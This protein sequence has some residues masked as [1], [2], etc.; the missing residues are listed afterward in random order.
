M[1]SFTG[2]IKVSTQVLLHV[3][4][5]LFLHTNFLVAF[6]DLTAGVCEN[7]DLD[8]KE[9][10]WPI[11]QKALSECSLDFLHILISKLGYWVAPVLPL[12]PKQR[13]I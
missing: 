4:D 8:S 2:V 13:R 1:Q 10:E 3:L 12:L 5:Q 7:V 6:A 9:E 11:I